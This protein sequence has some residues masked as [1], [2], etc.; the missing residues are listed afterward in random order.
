M[1][2]QGSIL[3]CRILSSAGRQHA[4]SRQGGQADVGRQA[5]GCRSVQAQLVPAADAHSGVESKSI[6]LDLVGE[7]G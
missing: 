6:V 2:R 5:A 4:R 7:G 1:C 3:A